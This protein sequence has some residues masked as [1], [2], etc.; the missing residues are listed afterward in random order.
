MTKLISRK[1][2]V[3]EKSWNF[4][5]VHSQLGYPGLY[6]KLHL[7]K[8]RALS[9]NRWIR[10]K[11][12]LIYYQTKTKV[13]K[14]MRTLEETVSIVNKNALELLMCILISHIWKVFNKKPIRVHIV[15][16]AMVNE[17]FVSVIVFLILRPI[18]VSGIVNGYFGSRK[19]LKLAYQVYAH[20]IVLGFVGQ[21]AMSILVRQ[22]YQLN[23][24]N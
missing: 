12:Q 23:L 13:L 7:I 20:L 14:I 17:F 15:T 10:E 3:A 18:Y 16:N 24:F 19:L 21:F 5:I 9:H 1:I 4:N 22:C 8:E 11:I 6:F 2:W